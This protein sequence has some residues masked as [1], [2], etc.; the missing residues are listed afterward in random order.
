MCPRNLVFI[1][2]LAVCHLQLGAQATQVLTNGLLSPQGETSSATQTSNAPASDVLPDDPEREL[3]PV[4]KPE[5]APETGTPVE[6]EA[7]RQEWAGDTLTLT[8]D[9]V[10]HYRDYV[11]RADSVVY[12]RKTT[13]LEADGDLQLSGGPNDVLINATHGDM[14]LNM[15]TARFYNVSGSQGVRTMGHTVVYST[16][17]PLLFSGRVLL[18]TG[19]GN[20]KVIDGSITNCR[21]PHPDW[22]IIAHTI[23]LD[24]EKAST[25]N[26][27]LE[28]LGVPVFYL[29]YLD[30]PANQTG[31][32]SGLLTPVV[33]VGSSIRGFTLGE[34]AYWV[35]NRSMDMVVGAEY[36]SKRGW[37]PNGDFRYKGP[38][39]D[40]LTARWNAL[41]DRGVEEEVGNTLASSA[42]APSDRLAGP[43]GYELVNQGGVD[44][45]V[46]GRKDLSSA[47]RVAGAVEYL[48]SYVYR[49]VFDDNYSQAI[50]SEVSSEVVLTHDH[51]GRMPTL[52]LDRFQSFANTT[53][54]NEVKILRLPMLRYD[55]LDRPLEGSPL[56]WGLGSSLGYLNRSEPFFHS[57]NVGR[58]DFNPHFS[59]P[60]ITGGW[61]FVPEV[62]LRD[63]AYTISQTPTLTGPFVVP[64]ISHSALNRTDVEA[65]VDIR[66]PALERDFELPH[67]HRELRHVIEPELTY[68]YVGGIGAKARDVLL[69]DTA[70]IA[71]DVNEAGFSL[72]QRFYLRPTDERPCKTDDER[73]ADDGGTGQACP[74]T[75]REWATWQIAQEYFIDPNF[76]G[77]LISGRRN[78]FDA[79]LDLM[80]P[81][82]LTSPRNIA[83]VV[84]RVRFEAIDN[85]RVQWDLDYD[86]IAGRI[87][88]N[89]LFAGYSFGRTTVGIGHAL[90]NAVD[91]RASSGAPSVIKSQQLQPFLEI[92]KP[93]GNGF[94][95]AVNGGYDFGQHEVQYGGVQA[96]YNWNCCGLT[97]GYRRF[98]LGTIGS[99][100]RDETQWLYSFTLANFGAVGDIRRS[101][102]V[103]RDP[104]LPPAY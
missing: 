60:F 20:F 6:W 16:P 78:V 72:T 75:P 13:E 3:V 71:T 34:Q 102:S 97:V 26:A 2:L 59:M 33:S 24:N 52:W 96:D 81:T 29:P 77:A 5:P 101:N 19:E 88:A 25:S 90:L 23:A 80:A 42:V 10:V 76:G 4:A 70:D 15:H 94:N 41:L 48:S 51:N 53:N 9:V 32:A 61:S 89:N 69:F 66:A 83:P 91:E 38:G 45:S 98:E 99:T 44:V 18:Q 73:A 82:F 63:T 21:L 64:Q 43:V 1:T 58:L 54:G 74:K 93:S 56:Y 35:I 46:L 85:L 14:R 68:R 37:A 39:L 79:T 30:H 22:R 7:K 67:W 100:S 65:S 84:S 11:L 17:T 92:G 57:R 31:R 95:L 86:S 62:A 47:T 49:L 104:T 50:S 12:N 103:F 27:F 8:G 28:F 55:V 87:A 36:Y 40:H